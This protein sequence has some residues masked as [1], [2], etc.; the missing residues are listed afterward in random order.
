MCTSLFFVALP[1]QLVG[2]PIVVGLLPT[3]TEHL[4]QQCVALASTAHLGNVYPKHQLHCRKMVIS[5]GI[6]SIDL[7]RVRQMA[8]VAANFQVIGNID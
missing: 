2:P 3:L 5:R 8:P 1:L 4:P 6:L 7:R